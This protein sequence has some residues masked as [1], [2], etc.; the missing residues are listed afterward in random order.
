MACG[1]D[2]NPDLTLALL[3]AFACSLF[4]SAAHAQSD[5]QANPAAHA[6]LAPSTTANPAPLARAVTEDPS[7]AKT[8]SVAVETPAPTVSALENRKLPAQGDAVLRRSENTSSAPI[9]MPSTARTI[10]SLL[11]VLALIATATWLLRRFLIGRQPA[12][13]FTGLEVLA[14]SPISPKQSLCLI[15]LGRK[16]LL[17]GLS[18]NHIGALQTIE[19]PE[20]IAQLLGAV[21][22]QRAQSISNGFARLFRRESDQYR[23]DELD[24]PTDNDPSAAGDTIEPISQASG[25]LSQLL[26]KVKGLSRMRLRP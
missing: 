24:S 17:V 22:Q 26:N 7:P 14:R 5:I 13:R 25:E 23:F 6:N 20:D 2:A 9:R 15:K 1:R 19:D 3:L 18:P 8:P 16:L 11:V 21:E 12:S 10:A 4:A